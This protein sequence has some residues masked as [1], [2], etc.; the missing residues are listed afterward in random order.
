MEMGRSAEKSRKM[1]VKELDKQKEEMER[2]EQNNYKE[3]KQRRAGSEQTH[4]VCVC[5]RDQN[6]MKINSSLESDSS[7]MS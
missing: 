4:S 2:Q 6:S 5:E 7:L 1:V 3:R